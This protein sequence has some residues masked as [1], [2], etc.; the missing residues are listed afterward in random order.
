MTVV[1]QIPLRGFWETTALPDGHVRHVRRFG[2]PRTL[3]PDETLWVVCDAARVDVNGHSIEAHD[4][5]FNATALLQP[6][7]ELAIE[8]AREGAPDVVLEIRK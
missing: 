8:N 6:R 1:H 7:N 4:G 3:D 5:A 2:R